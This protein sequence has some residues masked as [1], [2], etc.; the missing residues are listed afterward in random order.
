MATVDIIILV[1]VLVSALIGLVRGLLKEVLS[2]A[3]WLAAFMLALYFAPSVGDRLA[4]HLADES[5]RLVVAFIVI[6]LA[7]LLAGGLLQ[8]LAG[9]MIKS[10]GMSG[11]DRFLGFLFGAARGVLASLVALIALHQFAV[12][13]QWWQS[14]VLV[15]EM[16]A[17]EQDVLELMGK[18]QE[19]V[20]QLGNNWATEVS[21]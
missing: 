16:L 13:G 4:G 12:A 14:S 15:P 10:T 8:W 21:Q 9:T 20:V 7:T 5:V 1:V 2:L 19:W 17:F 11:T 6:F 3:S 18:A